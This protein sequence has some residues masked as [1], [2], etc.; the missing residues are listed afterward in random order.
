MESEM[1]ALATASE[2]ASWLRS[3]LSEIPTWKRPILAILIHCDSIAAIA[4]VQNRYYNGKR[5]QICCKH[6]TIRELL[7]TGAMIVDY[8]RSN[9]N[10]ADLL[11]KG[12]AREKT[13]DPKKQVQWVITDHKVPS[14]RSTLDRFTF[15]NVEVR[16]TFY[17]ILGRFLEYSLNW[18]IR[19]KP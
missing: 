5:R 18:D 10:L 13:G 12:L 14:Y 6:S 15:V 16:A 17:G 1:I 11:T 19:A 2:E 4:K 3:L 7:T 9:D 8:V